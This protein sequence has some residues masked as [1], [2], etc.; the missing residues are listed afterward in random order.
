MH[1]NVAPPVSSATTA[2]PHPVVRDA[3]RIVRPRDGHVRP[4]PSAAAAAV[5]GCRGRPGCAR[6]TRARRARPRRERDGEDEEPESVMLPSR[7][8]GWTARRRGRLP[9]RPRARGP[10][11]R[12]T[13]PAS[14]ALR[15]SVPAPRPEARAE[16]CRAAGGSRVVGSACVQPRPAPSSASVLASASPSASPSAPRRL[17]CESWCS[18][19]ERGSR[20]RWWRWRHHCARRRCGSRRRLRRRLGLGHRLRWRRG[21]R[22]IRCRRIGGRRDRG[23]ARRSARLRRRLRARLRCLRRSLRRSPL[24][25]CAV[26]RVAQGPMV[27]RRAP[28]TASRRPRARYRPERTQRRSS[29]QRG[30][31]VYAA[32]AETS[33]SETPVPSL[34]PCTVRRFG[35]LVNTR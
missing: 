35:S 23:R 26:R 2:A 4:E 7:C 3:G 14:T 31:R 17:S 13:R 27:V 29:P 9:R 10:R 28:A 20:R 24:G 34:S 12:A 21:E 1:V 11:P 33:S 19:S 18:W 8:G 5:A 32:A 6:R 16:A 22:R 25:R 15:R 30:L